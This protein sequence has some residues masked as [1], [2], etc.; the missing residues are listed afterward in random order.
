MSKCWSGFSFVNSAGSKDAKMT[1][2][3]DGR[4]CGVRKLMNDGKT[5]SINSCFVMTFSLRTKEKHKRL[6]KQEW[7][8]MVLS[9]HFKLWELFLWQKITWLSWG[10]YHKV[11]SFFFGIQKEY[12]D[13]ALNRKA[14][15]G[16]RL[17]LIN[18]FII[19]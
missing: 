10:H 16:L 3:S 9:L 12:W 1:R 18:I 11:V 4:G 7:P 14:L 15:T 13:G 19:N 17:Q 8:W 5:V 6:K 2:M